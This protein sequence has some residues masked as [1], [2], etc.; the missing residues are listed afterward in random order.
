M[1][2]IV[3]SAASFLLLQLVQLLMKLRALKQSLSEGM[4]LSRKKKLKEILQLVQLLRI[5]KLKQLWGRGGND[6]DVHIYEGGG[7]VAAGTVAEHI[8]TEA[9]VGM[10]EGMM[11]IMTTLQQ[12]F[13]SYC[14]IDAVI[15]I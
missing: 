5:L 14:A 3:L 12:T 4:E 9:V 15:K 6:D 11:I 13:E 10:R 7:P 2:K 8:E 1:V